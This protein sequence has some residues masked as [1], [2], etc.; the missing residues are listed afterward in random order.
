ML[1]GTLFAPVDLSINS[2]CD[3]MGGAGCCRFRLR[4]LF[5]C[6]NPIF[7]KKKELQN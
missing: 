7:F 3:Q 1:I 4:L 2:M 5:C 6:K